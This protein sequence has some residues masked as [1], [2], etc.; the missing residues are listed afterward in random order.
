MYKILYVLSILFFISCTK[1][2]DEQSVGVSFINVQNGDTLTS[3]FLLQMGVEGMTLEPKG[4]PKPGHGH[5]HLIVNSGPIDAGLI[6]IA[7]DNNIHY[8]GGQ[9][10][11]SVFLN[12][13]TYDLTLQFADGMHVSYGKEWAKSIQVIVK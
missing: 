11:D 7:D 6:I 4:E 10:E 5:H 1:S 2:N 3:P 13:G 12:P 9:S 8:G